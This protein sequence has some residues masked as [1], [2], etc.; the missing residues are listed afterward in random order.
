MPLG[1]V[2]T[3]V[4]DHEPLLVL[5]KLLEFQKLQKTCSLN[6]TTPGVQ[7]KE[8]IFWNGTHAAHMYLGQN[9]GPGRLSTRPPNKLLTFRAEL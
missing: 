6:F 9:L 2:N 4:Y 7:E 1:S 8:K 3:G 5:T